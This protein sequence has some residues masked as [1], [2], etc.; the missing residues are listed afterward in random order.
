[1]GVGPRMITARL[2]GEAVTGEIE[3]M[4]FTQLP[5]L[6]GET[7]LRGYRLD[8][9]RDRVAALGSLDYSWDL[10]R[11]VS[12]NVFCDAGRVYR[13]LDDLTLSGLRV[14]FGFGLEVYAGASY[15][16]RGLVGTSID[17]GVMFGFAVDS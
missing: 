2:Y 16:A 1:M 3:D 7:L 5:R 9:F 14:G 15:L 10:S 11:I 17:G 8:R 4:P 12:A 6:G 13:S